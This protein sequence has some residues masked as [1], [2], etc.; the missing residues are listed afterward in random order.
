MAVQVG[1]LRLLKLDLLIKVDLLLSD[2]VQFTD[3]IIDYLLSLLQSKVNFLNLVFNFFNLRLGVINHLVCILDLGVQV[4][5]QLLL[6]GGLEVLLEKRLPLKHQLSLL[7]A[8]CGHGGKQI[9]DLFDIILSLVTLGTD[10][11]YIELELG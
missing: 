4:I 11:S 1:D 10:V 5:G 3:L 7:L 6:L 8:D 9:L 2:Y